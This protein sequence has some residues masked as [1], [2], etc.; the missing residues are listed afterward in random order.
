MVTAA[1]SEAE[2]K[3]I[4]YIKFA[5][6]NLQGTLNW[7]STVAGEYFFL[8]MR[9]VERRGK[10][11][12]NLVAQCVNRAWVL[13]SC[14]LAALI[15]TCIYPMVSAMTSYSSW[16]HSAFLF[17]GN[18][19]L[20]GVSNTKTQ[21]RRPKTPWTKTKSPWTKTKTPWTKTKTPWT[22]MK[23]P[24]TK[25]KSSW[26]KTRTSW[27]KTKT[28]WTKTKTSWTK[29]KIPWTKT[30]IPWTKTNYVNRWGKCVQGVFVLVHGILGL[31]SSFLGLRFRNTRR[32]KA[33]SNSHQWPEHSWTVVFSSSAKQ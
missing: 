29:T 9:G 33:I 21:K 26:T 18:I 27:T 14:K 8:A 28:S 12:C 20:K 30:K 23:T 7:G 3:K 15:F 16:L 22:K 17:L 13:A 25:T 11:V 31:R 6:P 2:Y 24:W 32:M 19:R 5:Q 10:W 1:D 4:Y